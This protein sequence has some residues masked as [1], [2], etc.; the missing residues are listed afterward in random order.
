MLDLRNPL[1]PQGHIITSMTEHIFE[2]KVQFHEDQ[3]LHHIVQID[4]VLPVNV[5]FQAQF[6]SVAAVGRDVEHSQEQFFQEGHE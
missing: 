2:H 4:V 5:V 3:Y 1:C 6:Y